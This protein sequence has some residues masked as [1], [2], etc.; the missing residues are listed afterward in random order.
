M[1]LQSL[2][3]IVPSVLPRWVHLSF[4]LSSIQCTD[5]N[6][7][8]LILPFSRES[9][10]N[11][12][13]EVC[14]EVLYKKPLCGRRRLGLTGAKDVHILSYFLWSAEKLAT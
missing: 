4:F 6:K 13:S 8:R 1:G 3:C 14:W 10:E 9:E 5:D 7:V 12:H 11:N 2:D